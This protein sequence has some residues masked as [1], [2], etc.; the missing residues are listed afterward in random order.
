MERRPIQVY[1]GTSGW[2]Y[3][4][5]RGEFYPPGL[6]PEGFLRH[7]ASQL[8]AV[9]V[10]NTFYRMPKKSVLHGWSEQTPLSFRFCLKVSRRITHFGRLRNIDEP[11]AFLLGNAAELDERLGPLLLQLPPKFTVDLPLLRGFLRQL[12]RGF[13]VAF[14][15]R[16]RS[17]LVPELGDL[18][19]D[20]NEGGSRAALCVVGQRPQDTLDGLAD[21]AN[22]GYLRLRE[23]SYSDAD[24]EDWRG[25][26]AE[27]PW[28]EAYVFFKHEEAVS[29]PLLAKRFARGSRA[30]SRA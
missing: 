14:E 23:P 2:A 24:L 16:H 18:L 21:A 27:R 8:G 15:P 6:Q 4:S 30:I 12:P 9:E 11:L 25:W 22:F 7:Y 26:L 17:W 3:K 1:T 29:G 19:R 5:W 20:V 10:N 28:G 13:R